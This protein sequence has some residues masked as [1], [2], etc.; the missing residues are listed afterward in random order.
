[1]MR[2]AVSSS[3]GAA[4][5]L[6]P[7]VVLTLGPSAQHP[8]LAPTSNTVITAGASPL[9]YSAIQI[10]AGVTVR[11]VCPAGWPTPFTPAVVHCDGDAIVHGTLSVDGGYTNGVGF[12]AGVVR[13]GDGSWGLMCG[14]SYWFGQVQQG[15][16]HAGLYGSVLPFSLEGGSW[17]GYREEYTSGCF[18]FLRESPGGR[19]GGTLALVADGRIEVHGRVIAD[20]DTSGVSGGSGGSILLRGAGGV[21]VRPGGSVTASVVPY[22][23]LP[24]PPPQANG[25]PGYVRL[26]AWGTPPVIQGL[27]DP[28]PLLLELPH[29]RTQ[30]PPRI[31]TTWVLDVFAPE[32]SPIFVSV[33][34]RAGTGAATPFGP[35]GIDLPT[36]SGIA[37]TVAQPGH[38]PFANVPLPVPNAPILIGVPLWAQTFVLPPNLPPRLSNTI[39]TVVQ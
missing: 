1:M 6:F 5:R 31:G 37:L 3:W 22:P 32:S 27:V 7:S 33:S 14:G 23:G 36:A 15:G 28:Q 9:H 30:A 39:A 38:D 34:L 20:G 2:S 12:P 18:Q 25:G 13:I 11:F 10:P 26:D 24:G 17:G 21:F 4:V 19:G 35:L 8:V 16:R 29:L